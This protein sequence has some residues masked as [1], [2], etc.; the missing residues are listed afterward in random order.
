MKLRSLFLAALA[1]TA[2]VSCTNENDPIDEGKQV[3]KN[4][5]MQ[6]R[7]SF[8]SLASTR[9]D[10][11]NGTTTGSK[12]AG[13]D[14]EQKFSEALLIAAYEGGATPVIVKE[15]PRGQFA[16]V[17][18]PN[19]ADGKYYQ[20]APFEVTAGTVKAYVVL[21]PGEL[22]TATLTG[23]KTPAEVETALKAL[24]LTTLPA[25][26]YSFVMYGAAAEATVLADKTTTAVTV[27]VDR[28]VAKLKEETPNDKTSATV[29]QNFDGAALADSVTV[30]LQGYEF[31]NLTDKSHLVYQA[32]PMVSTFVSGSVFDGVTVPS[33][34]YAKT[35]GAPSA[36]D[37]ITYCWENDNAETTA[38]KG[39]KITSII[40]KGQITVAGTGHSAGENVYVYNNKAYN[41]A[42]LHAELP[43]LVLTDDSTI[44]QFDAI[45]IFKYKSG[46]CYYRRPI[47][48]GDELKK[49]SRNNVY[50]LSV[51]AIN[52]IGFP[53]PIPPAKKTMLQLNIEVNEW[54][55]NMNAFEL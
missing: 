4:A 55:V 10:E 13:L 33:F 39:D 41:F 14:L 1:A 17:T 47:L 42:E 12:E 7:V 38:D 30:S 8:G 43:G 49:I 45:G 34:G 54:T 11:T 37:Q 46:F 29:G 22:S 15:I 26:E 18:D 21:N 28:V 3:E 50:K 31:T 16:P 24:Q 52:T 48:T 5:M 36:T 25:Q 35:L 40:Y 19:T 9:V 53:T 32:S 44:V 2:M 27:A 23:N 20:S 6:F 51:T